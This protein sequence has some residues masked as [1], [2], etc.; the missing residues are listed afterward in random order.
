MIKALWNA[1]VL[2]LALNFLLLA[3]AVGWLFQSHRLDKAKVAAIRE[4]LFP[5]P[6]PEAPA[7][8]PATQPAEP[9]PLVRLEELL[10]QQAG[11]PAAEQAEFIR[12]TFDGQ[13]AQLDRRRREVEALR[14]LVEAGQAQ[15]RRD[16]AALEA[17]KDELAA[18][19]QEAAALA[20]DQGFQDS[21]K[22]YKTMPAK[23]VKQV[24]MSL[25]EDVVVRYLRAME[26]RMAAKVVKEFKTPQEVE[27]VQRILE[28][29]RLAQ[30]ATAPSDAPAAASAN[31]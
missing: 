14:D 27:R 3:G 15:L 28:K 24:F 9:E 21:L 6:A 22:L 10:A 12:R 13:N 31:E 25:D 20:A 23:Q 5:P 7:T 29:M 16:R 4:M 8:Q 11:R 17:E 1:V 30:P 2:A 18:R 19:A 26:P